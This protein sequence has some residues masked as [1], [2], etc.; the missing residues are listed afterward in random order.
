MKPDG[1]LYG[2]AIPP[3][4]NSY[5]G[6]GKQREKVIH[7]NEASSAYFSLI[8]KNKNNNNNNHYYNSIYIYI[9]SYG[10]YSQAQM[11]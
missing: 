1:A 7:S 6:C 5:V 11:T 2:A 10:S 8:E 4:R 9:C 3:T